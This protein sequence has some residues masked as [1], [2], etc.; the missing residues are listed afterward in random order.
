M[1]NFLTFGDFNILF[2]VTL[3]YHL[4]LAAAIRA[5]FDKQAAAAVVVEIFTLLEFLPT[6]GAIILGV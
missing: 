2:I 4:T 1:K 6:F 5:A 3:I